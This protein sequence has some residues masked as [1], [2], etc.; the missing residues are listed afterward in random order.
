[1]Y[2]QHNIKESEELKS[3]DKFFAFNETCVLNMKTLT[4]T[5]VMYKNCDDISPQRA[6]SYWH[7]QLYDCHTETV[8]SL[9]QYIYED[10]GL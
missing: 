1:M 5:A 2:Y 3:Y 10:E 8:C 7:Y 9:S 4:E 6:Q